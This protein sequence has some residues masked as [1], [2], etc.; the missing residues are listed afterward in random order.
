MQREICYLL[1]FLGVPVVSSLAVTDGQPQVPALQK[2]KKN[3]KF[4]ASFLQAHSKEGPI[5]SRDQREE[6]LQETIKAFDAAGVKYVLS[7]GSALG[8]IRDG[9]LPADDDDIDFLVTTDTFDLAHDALHDMKTKPSPSRFWSQGVVPDKVSLSIATPDF[10]RAEAEGWGPVEVWRVE[11][12]PSGVNASEPNVNASQPNL[13]CIPHWRSV[14]PKS[15]FF[16]P[17]L[18]ETN[19]PG[20][21]K[22]PV[23]NDRKD[24]VEYYYGKNWDKPQESKAAIFDGPGRGPQ[25]VHDAFYMMCSQPYVMPKMA[26]SILLDAYEHLQPT[27]D[28]VVADHKFEDEFGQLSNK[29]GVV[30]LTKSGDKPSI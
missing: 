9:R 15:M 24:F 25:I 22:V 12:A 10:V 17:R 21:L 30:N 18:V 14:I 4:L 7:F 1:V 5:V 29:F 8:I 28:W 23:P 6:A 20:G 2:D 16:P 27:L 11:D 3:S 19:I 26:R 13:L